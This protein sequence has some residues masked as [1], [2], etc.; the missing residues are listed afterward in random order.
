[1]TNAYRDEN[2][3]PTLIATSN[4]DGLA[5]VRVY[6]NPTN[7]G[8][9]INDAHTGT[10]HGNN[11]NIANRD[12]N[13]VPVLIAVSSVDGFTPVEVYSDPA[14]GQLLIDSL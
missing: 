5:I 13:D 7:H 12:E 3:V 1:M 9:K 10:D 2:N 8:L 11:S 14:T 6:A 4:A